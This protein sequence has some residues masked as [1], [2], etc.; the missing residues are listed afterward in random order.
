MG[1]LRAQAPTGSRH[2]GC[3]SAA[4]CQTSAFAARED[5]FFNFVCYSE[6]ELTQDPPSWLR[7]LSANAR[8]A[9]NPR[10]GLTCPTTT[11]IF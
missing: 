7:S 2:E 9:L 8:A 4:R 3:G 6:L 5:I 11:Q 10:S 1:T